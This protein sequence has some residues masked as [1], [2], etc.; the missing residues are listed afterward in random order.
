MQYPSSEPHSWFSVACAVVIVLE[1]ALLCIEF[2]TGTDDKLLTP[3]CF[4]VP[5]TLPSQRAWLVVP[6]VLWIGCW[7]LPAVVAPLAAAD[8]SWAQRIWRSMARALLAYEQWWETLSWR[9][10]HFLFYM[11][12]GYMSPC[13]WREAFAMS[14][15]WESFE[16]SAWG[17][18]L[19]MAM[20]K[21]KR[22]DCKAGGICGGSTDLVLNAL[23]LALGLGLAYRRD[24]L[25]LVPAEKRDHEISLRPARTSHAAT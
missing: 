25:P 12:L 2:V 24:S 1:M 20:W 14:V 21:T 18:E 10:A 11:M 19:L 9:T 15:L 3:K 17:R 5:E 22:T 7:L 16:C 13:Y 6:L 23:G 8:V 4:Y